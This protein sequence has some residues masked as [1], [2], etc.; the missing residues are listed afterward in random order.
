M[1]IYV[2]K[3]L[4]KN[5]FKINNKGIFDFDFILGIII[6]I[7]VLAFVPDTFMLNPKLNTL[8]N[9]TNY[10]LK[11]VE[12]QGNLSNTTPINWTNGTFATNDIILSNV[13]NMLYNAGYNTSTL[14][15]KVNGEIVTSDTIKSYPF[16]SDVTVTVSC[17]SPMIF[18][19]SIN[20]DIS[21]NF[22]N[23]KKGISTYRTR[24]R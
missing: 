6:L 9:A 23:S 5:R 2:N 1:K 13:T 4:K 10:V 19:N 21:P 20:P 22:S 8:S 11:T 14:E 7:S 3:L 12:K 15:V 17:K 16:E 24:T 18:S